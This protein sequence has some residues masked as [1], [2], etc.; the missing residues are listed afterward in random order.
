MYLKWHCVKT[1]ALLSIS[2]ADGYHP[3]DLINMHFRMVQ[4]WVEMLKLA[5][6]CFLMSLMI[7]PDTTS[8]NSYCVK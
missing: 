1:T 6:L 4:T 7:K 2:L 5:K 8:N 3:F